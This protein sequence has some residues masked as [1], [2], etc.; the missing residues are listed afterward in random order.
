MNLFNLNPLASIRRRLGAIL[1][2]FALSAACCACGATMTFVMAPR[3]ALQAAQISRM[4]VMDEPALAGATVGDDV[5]VTG[6]LAGNHVLIDGPALVAYR[7]EIWDVKIAGSDDTDSGGTPQGTWRSVKTVTPE[8]TLTFDGQPLPVHA[9]SSAR[10]S[11]PLHKYMLPGNG[12]SAKY[13]GKSLPGGTR[14]Y[15]GL[16]DGDM[17]TVLGK[18]APDGG[19]TPSELFLGDRAAFETSQ[20]Q[21]AS[22]LLF[23]GILLMVLS[24]VVL[25]G[26]LFAAIFGRRR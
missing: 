17:T 8:L 3:Q 4:P 16:A 20:H 10:L 5:L 23:S 26:G 19:V 1:G 15:Y 2:V 18:K 25:I 7:E 21:A 11:G 22:G 24:P 6:T 12:M 14:R 13:N 9:A